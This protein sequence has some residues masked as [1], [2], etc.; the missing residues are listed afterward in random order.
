VAHDQHIVRI[1]DEEA[2]PI[3]AGLSDQVSGAL[4]R[5]GS[6]QLRGRLG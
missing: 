2:A 1:D 6:Q 5:T 3:D 4:G